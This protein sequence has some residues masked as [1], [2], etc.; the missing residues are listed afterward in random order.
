MRCVAVGEV[1][2]V[3]PSARECGTGLADR[4]PRS[5][6]DG[7][8]PGWYL[9]LDSGH[10][11]GTENVPCKSSAAGFRRLP[12]WYLDVKCIAQQRRQFWHCPFT[13]KL[14]IVLVAAQKR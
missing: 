5:N 12:F 2:P 8:Q 1:A 4:G 6:L 7:C 14:L 9:P 13:H 3:P 11:V 10:Q